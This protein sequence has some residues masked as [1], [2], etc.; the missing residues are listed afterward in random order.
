MN[1][2]SPS[3]AGRTDAFSLPSFISAL[4]NQRTREEDME[5]LLRNKRTYLTFILPALLV[6]TALVILPIGMSAYYSTLD[7]DGIG[8]GTFVGLE[9]FI[10]LFTK[11]TAFTKSIVNSLVLAVVSIVLEIIPGGI[12]AI[13]LARGFPGEKVFRTIFFIPV[14]LSSVVIGQLFLKIYNSNYG[15]LNAI[16]ERFGGTGVDWLGNQKTVL[17]AT[18]FPVAYQYLGYHMLLLYTA[19]KSVPYDVTEAAMIDGASEWRIA[20]NI[21]LPLIKPMIKTCVTFA[22][23][24]SLKFFDLVWILTKGGPLHA[25]EVPTTL[26]YTTIFNRNEYGIG[27]AIAIF[28]VLECLMFYLLIDKLFKIEHDC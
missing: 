18:F 4:Q 28:V 10:N 1:S 21:T 8:N 16:I 26:M 5:K 9:N 3:R 17:L 11:N 15:L 19:A 20:W 7:W 2:I 6:Y 14:V 25:S 24:G 23:I 12:I 27:S 22:V 13:I